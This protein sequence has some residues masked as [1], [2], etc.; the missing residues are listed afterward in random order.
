MNQSM[1]HLLPIYKLTNS[2]EDSP[3]RKHLLMY[4]KENDTAAQQ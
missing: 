2:S 4:M 3:E 1:N